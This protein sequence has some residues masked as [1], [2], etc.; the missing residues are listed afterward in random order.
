MNGKFPQDNCHSRG[1]FPHIHAVS[2]D[3]V[4]GDNMMMKF[5]PKK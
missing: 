1:S 5:N 2:L 4:S 3:F